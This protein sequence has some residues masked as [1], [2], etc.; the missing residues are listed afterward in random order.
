MNIS[1]IRRRI[2]DLK[3]RGFIKTVRKGSTGIGHTLEQALDLTESNISLPDFG[4]V[5]LKSMRIRSRVI[6]FFTLNK[7]AWKPS[8]KEVIKKYGY[9]DDKRKRYALYNSVRSK[10]NRKGLYLNITK[11]E[12]EICHV[13]GEII[14]IWRIQ[15]VRDKII[16][17]L[18]ALLLVKAETKKI[19][20]IEHFWYKEATILTGC[21][22]DKF[23]EL[24]ENGSTF[25]DI[26]MHIK[27]SGSARNHGTGFRS[28][29]KYLNDLYTNIVPLME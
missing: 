10:P 14:A 5:E 15:D 11:T 6:T 1:E 29:K 18:Q 26:R 2:T 23:F 16:E 7:I 20:N 3:N 19:D 13:Q 22:F 4:S 17:K 28:S 21:N 9:W 8:A 25:I 24:L 12:I 27:E